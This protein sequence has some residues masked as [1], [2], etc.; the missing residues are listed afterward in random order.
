MCIRDS[1]Y[2]A[3]SAEATAR[4]VA[5]AL[6]AD[7]ALD[8]SEIQALQKHSILD[9]LRIDPDVF[10][11]VMHEFCNDVLQSARAPNIGQ[12]EIDREVIDHLLDDIP[13][14]Y[15][16]LL[17]ARSGDVQGSVQLLVEAAERVPNLQFLV[18]A[19]KAIFTLLELNGW[20]AT[21]AKRGLRYLALAQAK[22]MRNH[23]VISAREIYQRVAR[24]YGVPIV[25]LSLIHI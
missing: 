3:D 19:T 9:N 2:T 14:S 12:I 6:L 20:D 18:N 22:D 24:K 16:H 4:V 21:L 1:H 11:R 23:K 15:T 7:G 8:N 13:V 10:D 17:A 25:P 5:L